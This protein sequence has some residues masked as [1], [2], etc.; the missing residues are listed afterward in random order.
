MDATSVGPVAFEGRDASACGK[1]GD[2][3]VINAAKSPSGGVAELMAVVPGLLDFVTIVSE[4]PVGA[5]A[6]SLNAALPG[7]L[8]PA[9]A[10][11]T[12]ASLA[13]V[14]GMAFDA[15]AP[16]ESDAA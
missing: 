7:A 16:G 6:P 9:L 3:E 10:I 15:D 12:G 4:L 5:G 1:G 14:S 13:S 8:V 11:D 2:S